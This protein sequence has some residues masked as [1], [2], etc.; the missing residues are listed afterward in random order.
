M[1]C[2]GLGSKGS[3]LRD[4]GLLPKDLAFSEKSLRIRIWASSV[5]VAGLKFGL[6]LVQ[7]LG[8]GV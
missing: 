4:Q 3:G 5:S 1:A 2:K 8:L 6:K 7:G